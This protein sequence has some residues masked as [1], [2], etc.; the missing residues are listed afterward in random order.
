M[1]TVEFLT[2]SL[3][4]VL[5]PGT[6]IVFTVSTGL[7]QGRSASIYAGLGCGASLRQPSPGSALKSRLTTGEARY[8][9]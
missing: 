6:G 5:I 4:V 3:I 8:V 1:L 2:T 9:E 7:A